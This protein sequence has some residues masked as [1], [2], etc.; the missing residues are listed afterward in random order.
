IGAR[1]SHFGWAFSAASSA[2]FVCSRLALGTDAIT[3]SVVGLTTS[4]LSSFSESTHS[5]LMYIRYR[6]AEARATEVL[7]ISLGSPFQQSRFSKKPCDGLFFLT[8]E[9]LKRL[10]DTPYWHSDHSHRF[11]QPCGKSSD[12]DCFYDWQ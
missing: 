2:S 7:V 6:F 3:R 10:S 5:P 8:G 4:I 12:S 1:S 9:R 11:F